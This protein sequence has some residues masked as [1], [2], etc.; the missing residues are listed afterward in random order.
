MLGIAVSECQSTIWEPPMSV[1]PGVC[2]PALPPVVIGGEVLRLAAGDFEG[3][4]EA[5]HAAAAVTAYTL[6]PAQLCPIYHRLALYNSMAI[7][8]GFVS[9]AVGQKPS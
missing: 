1:N 8:V 3:G 4:M 6:G 2:C 5:G 7:F 9:I